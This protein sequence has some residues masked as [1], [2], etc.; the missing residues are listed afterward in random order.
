MVPGIPPIQPPFRVFKTRIASPSLAVEN[1]ED[2]GSQWRYPPF[3]LVYN[4]KNP[5][6]ESEKNPVST[7]Q[8]LG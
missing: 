2:P 3:F 6:I 8:L 7:I 4:Q 1:P 5:F